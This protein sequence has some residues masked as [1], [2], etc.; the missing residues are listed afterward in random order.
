L[1]VESALLKFLRSD[2]GH[3]LVLEFCIWWRMGLTC[4]KRVWFRPNRTWENG[5]GRSGRG[6]LQKSTT[7]EC[8]KF[9]QRIGHG[10]R[11]NGGGELSQ[12]QEVKVN[13]GLKKGSW[14]EPLEV[15]ATLD[16]HRLYAEADH[17]TRACLKIYS[18]HP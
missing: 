7:R 10:E 13:R 9:Y 14:T 3:P 18:S 5:N 11:M 6:R 1:P 8:L 2:W 4:K 17:G 12:A 16:L 15:T